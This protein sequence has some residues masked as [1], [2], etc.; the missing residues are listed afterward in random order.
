V[1]A[2]HAPSL[3][4]CNADMQ[5]TGCGRTS[6]QSSR[7]IS[8]LLKTAKESN[9]FSN[10]VAAKG[11]YCPVHQRPIGIAS[12]F[13]GCMEVDQIISWI[14]LCSWVYAGQVCG[15]LSRI[16]ISMD[17]MNWTAKRRGLVSLLATSSRMLLLDACLLTLFSL[18]TL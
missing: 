6:S 17:S 8:S 2:G 16:E 1:H 4:R 9:A 10:Y 7:G 3:R 11:I 5:I 12:L 18:Y 14:G 15:D 13:F